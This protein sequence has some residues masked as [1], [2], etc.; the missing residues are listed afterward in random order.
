M[1]IAFVIYW[2]GTP[3]GVGRRL[4]RVYSAICKEN[5][6][7]SCD[8]I[9]ICGN[10]SEDYKMLLRSQTQDWSVENLNIL[11]YKPKQGLLYLLFSNK[12]QLIHLWGHGRYGEI[13]QRIYRIK[14]KKILY[15]VCG[16]PEAYNLIPEFKM[17][18]FKKHLRC[19]DC[20]DLLYPAAEEF[21]RQYTNGKLFITP[22][23][24]TDLNTFRPGKKE[25][26]LV[27]AAARLDDNK[28]PK[29]FVRAVNLC[30]D[31]IRKNGYRVIILGKG[32]YEEYIKSYI[33]ENELGDIINMVGYQT[34]SLYLPYAEVF[35]SLQKRENYP[36]QSLAE[37]VACGC[38]S[39]ITDV[40]DS[41]KCAEEEFAEFVDG[42]D[43]SVA[44][45]ICRYMG[46]S[47]EEKRKVISS[48]RQYALQN[49]TIEKS[50]NYYINLLKEVC[51][52]SFR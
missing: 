43:I 9:A 8:I 11:M 14:R 46:K 7:I 2:S 32:L 44:Q 50:K 3:G 36:S 22:G 12:Y 49:Y 4:S 45:A 31:Q 35:F 19:A 17:D 30:Q 51:G 26:T 20:V 42:N 39:I 27:Y 15:T 25:K 47:D 21:I 23:T 16:Y 24:F 1:K 40:G 41:R 28:D 37:A 48:A 6:N 52:H 18:S 38:Y 13:L 34:T 29:L 10:T 33:N 5:K